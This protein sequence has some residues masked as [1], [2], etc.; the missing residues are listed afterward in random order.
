MIRADFDQRRLRQSAVPD[1]FQAV[2]ERHHIVL[3]GSRAVDVRFTG[4]SEVAEDDCE[5]AGSVEVVVRA[6][7]ATTR[8]TI[9]RRQESMDGIRD[10]LDFDDVSG[11][12][13]IRHFLREARVLNSLTAKTDSIPAHQGG[14]RVIQQLFAKTKVFADSPRASGTHTFSRNRARPEDSDR[15]GLLPARF[16]QPKRGHRTRPKKSFPL[17]RIAAAPS[18][19]F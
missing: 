4:D 3:T 12:F 13:A 19:H 6:I 15:H 16:N 18:T 17:R 10:R 14:C 9:R 2:S 8:L 11:E 5:A 7:I 1:E